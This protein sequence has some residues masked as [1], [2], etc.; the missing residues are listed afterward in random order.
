MTAWGVKK[1]HH[2]YYGTY[3]VPKDG[4][5]VTYN[6][7]AQAQKAA[8]ALQ[9]RGGADRYYLAHGEHSAPTYEVV[10]VRKPRIDIIP[11]EDENE[12]I[13]ECW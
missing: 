11:N 6:T 9:G 1:V 5:M 8:E 2:Y 7:K 13:R 4:I 3:N 12:L 10:V